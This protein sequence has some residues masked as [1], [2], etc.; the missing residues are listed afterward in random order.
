MKYSCSDKNCGRVGDVDEV[1]F[2][3]YL[4]VYPENEELFVSA[5]VCPECFM[6]KI[7]P[8]SNEIQLNAAF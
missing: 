6:K 4:H 7:A 2:M 3:Q 5:H 8:H 1:E